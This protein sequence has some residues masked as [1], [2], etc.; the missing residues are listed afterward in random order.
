MGDVTELMYACCV[1]NNFQATEVASDAVPN[2][3]PSVLRNRA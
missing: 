1:E 3:P 2:V